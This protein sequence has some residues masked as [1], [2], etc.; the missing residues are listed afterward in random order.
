MQLWYGLSDSQT[1]YHPLT[2]LFS[3]K[4]CSRRQSGSPTRLQTAS[5]NP[6]KYHRKSLPADRSW[7]FHP[8][9]ALKVPNVAADSN[10]MSLLSV[11]PAQPLTLAQGQAGR[12]SVKHSAARYGMQSSAVLA[13]AAVTAGSSG[14]SINR[15]ARCLTSC[16][17]CG[18][19]TVP[20]ACWQL[21]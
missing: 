19:R 11:S 7:R 13:V 18:T 3:C 15:R 8:N 20:K 9:T 21:C 12:A 16:R 2:Q 10:A 4:A 1:H 6:A 5:H 17:A 14:S